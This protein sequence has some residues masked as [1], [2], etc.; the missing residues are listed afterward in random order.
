[1]SK[2]VSNKN[3][4][5]DEIVQGLLSGKKLTGDGGLLNPFIKQ[6]VEAALEAEIDSHLATEVKK[7]R[8][9]GKSKKK[10][11]TSNGSFELE[12]PRDRNSSFNPEI[13][14]KGQ[15]SFSSE[16]EEKILSLYSL[17][18]S[19]RDMK[20]HIKEMYQIEISEGTISAITDKIIPKVKE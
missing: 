20:S 7:N 4:E 10:M 5:F 18:M 16:I 3:L 13:V 19:Y 12:V 9:N 17:G 2:T 8:K 14:K 11:K 6:V 15:T 1:M